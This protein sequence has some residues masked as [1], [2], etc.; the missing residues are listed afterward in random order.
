MIKNS[1][2]HAIAYSKGKVAK[3]D[4]PKVAVDNFEIENPET[5]VQTSSNEIVAEDN[6]QEEIVDEFTASEELSETTI[7][8]V[9][10]QDEDCR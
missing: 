7:S 4:F 3:E 5:E 9:Y 10:S 2:Q 1:V 6:I 8:N